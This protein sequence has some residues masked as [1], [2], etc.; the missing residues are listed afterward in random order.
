MPWWL[1]CSHTAPAGEGILS[2]P[3]EHVAQTVIE[4]LQLTLR[5]FQCVVGDRRQ[6]HQRVRQP[7]LRPASK[8]MGIS[9]V[10]QYYTL[11]LILM[12]IP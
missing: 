10:V 12:G 7:V 3:L 5:E 9:Q 4:P 8:M 11:R 2:S 1:W 6:E